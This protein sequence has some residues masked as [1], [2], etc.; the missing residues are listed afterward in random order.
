MTL[1]SLVKAEQ[2]VN[3]KDDRQRGIGTNPFGNYKDLTP[4]TKQ[5]HKGALAGDYELFKFN[6][7]TGATLK[8][9]V[10]SAVFSCYYGFDLIALCD[11]TYEL[12]DGT[13]AGIGMVD[14]K[15]TSF[16]IAITGG[17]GTYDGARGE[18]QSA[19]AERHAQRQ[20]FVLK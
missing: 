5:T 8:E 6:V 16:A 12:N 3:T 17:T 1:Y 11:A 13:L 10:G 20:L 15:T 14:F 9:R 7:Y 4:T 2:F 18:V 19:A